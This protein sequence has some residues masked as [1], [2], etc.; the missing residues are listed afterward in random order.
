MSDSLTTANITSYWSPWEENGWNIP[1]DRLGAPSRDARRY[2]PPLAA[3]ARRLPYLVGVAITAPALWL[4][5]RLSDGE[6]IALPFGVLVVVVCTAALTLFGPKWIV[7]RGASAREVDVELQLRLAR[8]GTAALARVVRVVYARQKTRAGYRDGTAID[9]ASGV[10]HLELET[11]AGVQRL[12]LEFDP[13]EP[14]LKDENEVT[15]LYLADDSSVWLPVF[16]MND[17]E[18]ALNA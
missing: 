10:A 4:V 14:S 13:R 6:N 3:G 12:E 17:I 7:D 11:P 1:V 16:R 15:V 9:T 5:S 8:E 2:Q 18:L